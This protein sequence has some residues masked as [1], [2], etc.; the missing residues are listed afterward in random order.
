MTKILTAFH[1][2]CGKFCLPL[3]LGNDPEDFSGDLFQC[4]G[5][6]EGWSRKDY[7]H[8]VQMQPVFIKETENGPT[9]STDPSHGG[10]LAVGRKSSFCLDGT[11]EYLPKSKA[12]PGDRYA[13]FSV[14]RGFI[15]MDQV[16]FEVGDVI[17][18]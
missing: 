17:N 8:S 6:R 5:C 16:K 7:F 3:P 10:E 9:I 15:L 14:R 18:A 4:S 2:N 11:V 1:R 12:Q 13:Y